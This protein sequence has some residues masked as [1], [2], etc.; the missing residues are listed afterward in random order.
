MRWN[1][2]KFVAQT[3]AIAQDKHTHAPPVV[4]REGAI[5]S[6]CSFSVGSYAS[7]SWTYN[8]TKQNNP[9]YREPPQYGLTSDVFQM[10]DILRNWYLLAPGWLGHDQLW[11]NVFWIC[12]GN[13][14]IFTAR[15]LQGSQILQKNVRP[16]N[17][18]HSSMSMRA[19]FSETILYNWSYQFQMVPTCS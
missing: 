3:N 11:W 17:G 8:T 15:V 4:E 16:W 5:G 13:T 14:W 12:F 7:S 1:S 19:Y 9:I 18:D 2:S 6:W 10:I